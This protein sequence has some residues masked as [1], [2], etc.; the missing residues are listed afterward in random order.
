MEYYE[1]SIKIAKVCAE[2][3]PESFETWNLLAQSYSKVGEL[4]LA[5]VA[6]DVAPIYPDT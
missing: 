2:M 6:L 1:F 4:K 5:L 3:C